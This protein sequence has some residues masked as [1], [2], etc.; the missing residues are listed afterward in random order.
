VE[1]IGS[2]PIFTPDYLGQ[3]LESQKQSSLYRYSVCEL[4]FRSPMA[5]DEELQSYYGGLTDQDWWQYEDEREVWQ[6]IREKLVGA[7]ARTVLDVGC[8]RGDL[9]GYLG[10]QWEKFGV[11][12]SRDARRVAESR[13][14]KIISDTID[15]L[16]ETDIRFGAITLIDVIEHLPRPL[17][18]LRKLADL[19]EPGG[20]LMI[21]TGATD[22]LSWRFART[23]YWYCSMPEHVVFF[24]PSWFRW[25]APELGCT[26]ESVQRLPFQRARLSVR[27]HEA[28]GN[29]AYVSYHRLAR[30]PGLGAALRRLPI[31]KRIGS[32]P[33]SWWTSAC[34]HVL[35]MLVKQA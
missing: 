2:L 14:I 3:P 19:L 24:R 10:D 4:R 9:L 16:V 5:T 6:H 33:G 12:P 28:L 11:E 25:V 22:A 17:D 32:W 7:P 8:F 31:V 35:V 29:I 26:V 21:F 27:L 13:G 1:R 23:H 30:V 20:R 34:D 18:S 15:S